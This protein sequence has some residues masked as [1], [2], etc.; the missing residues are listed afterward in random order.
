MQLQGELGCVL[1]SHALSACRA[2][3]QCLKPAHAA[4]SLKPE[5]FKT[6]LLLGV[7]FAWLP[8][9]ERLPGT[10]MGI[11]EA[12]M[13]IIDFCFKYGACLHFAS[14]ICHD[15]RD[16]ASLPTSTALPA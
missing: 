16:L 5:G 7:S 6:C 11:D 13:A 4:C 10:H 14:C 2:I 15:G 9:R 12:V 8:E 1:M 3:G